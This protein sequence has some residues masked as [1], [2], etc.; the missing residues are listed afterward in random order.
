MPLQAAGSTEKVVLCKADDLAPG[1]MRVV[2]IG[3][4]TEVIVCNVDGR[5][6][7]I[8]SRCSHADV[9]LIDGDLEGDQLHCPLHGGCFDVW[10]GRATS[11]PAK[12]PIRTYASVIENGEVRLAE[13]IRSR[14]SK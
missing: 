7:V 11:R 8:A 13:D 5:Y 4:A 14:E 12:K 2:E 9:E 1:E 6:S 10:S 3:D